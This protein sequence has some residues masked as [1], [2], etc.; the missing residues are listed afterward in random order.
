MQGWTQNQPKGGRR[1]KT[2]IEQ[3]WFPKKPRKWTRD[4]KNLINHNLNQIGVSQKIRS[5]VSLKEQKE[6]HSLDPL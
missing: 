4:K 1:M 5:Q 6:S 3:V 2:T